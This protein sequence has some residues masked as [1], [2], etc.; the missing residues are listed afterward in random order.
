MIGWKICEET[1]SKYN[2]CLYICIQILQNKEV[3]RRNWEVYLG[4]TIVLITNRFPLI[5]GE[6]FLID[7]MKL[8]SKNEYKIILFPMDTKHS[9]LMFNYNEYPNIS[10]REINNTPKRKLNRLKHLSQLIKIWVSEI[11]FLCKANKLSCVTLKRS[12]SSLFFAE[13]VRCYIED[14]CQNINDKV[15]LYSY[16]GTISALAITLIKNENLYK[17]TRVH[18]VDLYEYCHSN[19]YLPYKHY[20]YNHLNSIISISETGLKYI[21]EKYPQIKEKVSVSR[22]GTDDYG[23]NPEEKSQKI[24]VVS[25]SNIIE[26]KRVPLICKALYKIADIQIHWVH[27]GDGDQME[28][29]K[30]IIS[31][32]NQKN[33][34]IELKGYKLK[35]EIL[36]WYANN[37][38][39]IFI[40][41]SLIEGVPVSIMEA[42][43]FGIPAIATDVGGTSEIVNNTNGWLINKET[44]QKEIINAIRQYHS[45][46]RENIRD[47]R[48][49]AR[50]TWE[51]RYSSRINYKKFYENIEKVCKQNME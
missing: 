32:N 42:Y 46:N 6:P 1:I 13:N 22:L 27:F 26:V 20:I 8:A 2:D 31:K 28:N 33:L 43:S 36:E 35:E 37:H 24:V 12:I 39:D 10:M 18:R 21:E 38:V 48:F 30:N 51:E 17:L 44:A 7:E 41:A 45:M 14:L 3:F 34:S 25:C 5:K 15:V 16:W 9:T 4:M 50:K 40:N 49:H 19:D 23:L 29:V 11:I 47:K